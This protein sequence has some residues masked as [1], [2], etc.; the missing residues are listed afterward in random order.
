MKL[1]PDQEAL[2]SKCYHPSGVF[3]E[4]PLADVGASIPE[5]FEKIVRKFPER[6]AVNDGDRAFTYEELNQAANRIAHS[7]VEQSATSERPIALLFEQGA[8]VIAAILGVLKTGRIYVPLDPSV[9]AARISVMLQD[10]EAELLLTNSQNFLQAGQ[11]AQ[12]GQQIINCDDVDTTKLVEN[13]GRKIVATTPALILYTSGSTGKPKGVL[14]SHRNILVEA[15]NYINDVRLCPDDALSLCQSCSFAN[16]IRNIYGALLSGAALFPYDLASRGIPPLAEWMHVHRITIFHTL[17]TIIRRL[18][19]TIAADTTFPA[20]RI[21]RFGGEPSSGRDVK[22]FQHRF[23]P[24]C[25]LMNVIGS[26]E[27]FTIRRYFVSPDGSGDDNKIPLGYEV[28]GK[29]IILLDEAGLAVEAGQI[30]E[31]AVRSEHLALGYWR[32]PE[33]TRAV[34][35]SDPIGGAKRLYMTGDLGMMRADGCLIHMGRKD[36]QI[37]IRGNRV[38]VTEIEAELLKLDAIRAAV[39]HAQANDAG[40]HR[41]IA[42]VVPDAAK[43]PTISDLRRALAPKLPDY[44][45]PSAFVFLKSIPVVPN[46]RVDRSALPPPLSLRPELETAFVVARTSVEKALVGIWSEVLSLDEI[47]ID[48]DFFELGGHSLLAA[49][50]FAAL[51]EKFGRSY[52]LSLL[53][54]SPTIRQLAEHYSRPQ[55]T[56]RKLISLVPLRSKGGQTPIFAVPGVFGNVLGFVELARELGEDR[57]FYGLQSVGLDGLQPPLETIEAMVEGYIKEIRS[58]RNSGPYIIIGACFGATVAYEMAR[59][60]MATGNEVLY[61]GLIDPNNLEFTTDD[62]VGHAHFTGWNKAHTIGNLLAS[63]IKAYADELRHTSGH[64]RLHF[65]LRKAVSV[66]ATLA[67]HNKSTR[68]SREIHQLEVANA[69]RRALRRYHRRPLVGKLKTFEVFESNHSRNSRSAELALEMMWIGKVN[70]YQ[71]TARDS[72]DMLSNENA[73]DL[74]R[75]I[76]GRIDTAHRSEVQ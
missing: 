49:K 14:H 34:F 9:P 1:V 2:R 35:I 6:L 26:T 40:E 68:L 45:M 24:N 18:L 67:N 55:E 71:C 4:F 25:V 60:L 41:L 5:C 64:E 54:S 66:G 75:R 20:L 57:P 29:E 65:L 48:D 46:G 43:V 61:L 63:R 32:Q 36:F 17:E 73:V 69:N 30:G 59:E 42:D 31:I 70:F 38:E 56:R 51:D 76:G 19:D 11:L 44:M 15:S 50:M 16:S 39:V 47:G 62:G 28:P 37:K 33:L 52:P 23:A 3:V 10:S 7:I 53:L 12:D 27:T 8:F 74:A 58:V 21:L 22:A 13:L 72:G